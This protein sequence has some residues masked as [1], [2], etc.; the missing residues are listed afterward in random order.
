MEQSMKS[1]QIW[2]THQNSD[3]HA[4]DIAKYKSKS[5]LVF[6]DSDIPQPEQMGAVP[7]N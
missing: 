3:P 2:L 6:I 4:E 7:N 5:V 1:Q